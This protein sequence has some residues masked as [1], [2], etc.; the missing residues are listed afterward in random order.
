[1]SLTLLD[2]FFTDETMWTITPDL[3]HYTFQEVVGKRATFVL[4]PDKEEYV[5]KKYVDFVTM[6]MPDKMKK[7]GTKGKKYQTVVIVNFMNCNFK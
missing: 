1:M 7:K 5:G 3:T 2:G 4:K 6:N